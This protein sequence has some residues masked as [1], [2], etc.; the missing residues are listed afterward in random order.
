M[1]I[2]TL[3]IRALYCLIGWGTVGIVYS[4]TGQ[5]TDNVHLL[6]P[7]AVDSAVP[8]SP[9]AVWFY[10]SFFLFIPLGYFCSPIERT[11]SLMFAMQL[12]ALVSGA[13][14]LLYPTTMQYYD[15]DLTS[16]SA[17]ALSAL[18]KIDSPQNLLPSLHVSLT[19]VVLNALWSVKYKFR[20]LLYFL[21]A[22]AICVSVLVLKRHLF[23]DV[24]TGAVTA[25]GALLVV[26]MAKYGLERK[27]S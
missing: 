12:C 2:K 27:R 25:C 14:Y 3:F 26:H 16:F 4:Y 22:T 20:T 9:S 17:H 21:W 24:I 7:S 15:Y 13:V 23:I 18:I 8:F 1:N 11:R 5:N 6:A 10:L 19:L